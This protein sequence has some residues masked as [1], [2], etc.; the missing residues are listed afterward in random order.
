MPTESAQTSPS[1]IDTTHLRDQRTTHTTCPPEEDRQADEP[2]Q[3][4]NGEE[5][6]QGDMDSAPSPLPP[7]SVPATAM[8]SVTAEIHDATESL[9]KRMDIDEDGPLRDTPSPMSSSIESKESE[10]QAAAG[11]EAPTSSIAP[12]PHASLESPWVGMRRVR[13]ASRVCIPMC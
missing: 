5:H 3:S 12:V 1:F 7:Q 10:Q 13:P 6:R 4:A 11:A 8:D 2:T 9:A